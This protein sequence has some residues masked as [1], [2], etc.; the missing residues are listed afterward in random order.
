MSRHIVLGLCQVL[1]KIESAISDII[2]TENFGTGVYKLN[3]FFSFGF[4]SRRK[5]KAVF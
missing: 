1:E 2:S 3:K 4:T 5:E